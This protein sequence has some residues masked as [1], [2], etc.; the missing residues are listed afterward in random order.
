MSQRSAVLFAIL[1]GLVATS[2][3]A[4]RPSEFLS[5]LMGRKP[6]GLK[7]VAC[8]ARTYDA[9]Y[10]AAHPNQNVSYVEAFVVAY[11]N[12]DFAYQL[13]LGF[14]FHGQPETYTSVGE[15]GSYDSVRHGARCAGPNGPMWLALGSKGS[16]LME[17]PKGG[18]LWR[19]GPPN[20]KDT[21]KGAFGPDD[22]LFRLDRVDLAQCAGQMF[23]Y[24][25]KELLDER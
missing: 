14:R 24:E 25:R 4:A 9:A 7:T 6:E 13:R 3:L 2:A 18:D 12:H 23:D 10:V 5:R 8:F 16:M 15:C 17:L 22:K 20:P 19:P 11:G 21:L 1:A